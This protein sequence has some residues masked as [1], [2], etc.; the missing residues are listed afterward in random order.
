MTRTKPRRSAA[1]RSQPNVTPARPRRLVTALLVI[2]V[3][4]AASWTWSLRGP[5]NPEPDVVAPAAALDPHTAFLQGGRL[6]TEGRHV[7]SIPYFRRALADMGEVWEGRINLAAALINS[8]LEVKTRL[9]RVDPALRSSYERVEAVRDGMREA[10]HALRVAR[11]AH[12]RA[13]TAYQDAQLL[14]S[15]GFQWDALVAARAA[16]SFEPDWE[17]PRRLMLEI[18]RDLARGGVAP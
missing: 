12:S 10:H 4:I 6:G 3:A 14:Q 15:W 2:A 17:P 9:G 18:Q 8:G 16:Q 13:Y 1:P 5:R 11:D 7:E